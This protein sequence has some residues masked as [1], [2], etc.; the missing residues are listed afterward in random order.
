MARSKIPQKSKLYTTLTT[1]DTSRL[2][3][4]STPTKSQTFES[5]PSSVS[6]SEDDENNY[7][8]IDHSILRPGHPGL[9]LGIGPN[10]SRLPLS[11]RPMANT[12]DGIGPPTPQHR[13]TWMKS[14]MPVPFEIATRPSMRSR[15]EK[16]TEPR[17]EQ[18]EDNLGNWNVGGEDDEDDDD[19]AIRQEIIN[20][21]ASFPDP[22]DAPVPGNDPEANQGNV[23]G[24]IEVQGVENGVQTLSE[25]VANE[26]EPEPE[27]DGAGDN[28]ET[29]AE[30]EDGEGLDNENEEVVQGRRGEVQGER[31][32]GPDQFEVVS[33]NSEAETIIG[34]DYVERPPRVLVESGGSVHQDD[35]SS[36][37]SDPGSRTATLFTQLV[38]SVLPVPRSTETNLGAVP[39]HTLP[40]RQGSP[41]NYG[42][43]NEMQRPTA[44][45]NMVVRQRTLGRPTTIT[46]THADNRTVS[47]TII[48]RR[49][50]PRYRHVAATSSRIP[51]I[52]QRRARELDRDGDRVMAE[53]DGDGG[54]QARREMGSPV[55]KRR[56]GRF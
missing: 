31:T 47:R 4:P 12:I 13:R 15:F 37:L 32:A 33:D 34:D 27:E 5:E 45:S 54:D 26:A 1:R 43:E 3:K 20:I 49:S 55:R 2:A 35:D 50:P 46:R 24:P 7:D 44:S 14:I 30:T 23:A 36:P 40:S 10:D 53:A 29:G 48:P 9:V 42:D 16:P 11:N 25:N 28:D 18:F 51:A 56:C 52:P 6:K 17:D 38:Q 19:D 22:P 8:Y 39:M 21:I 41:E